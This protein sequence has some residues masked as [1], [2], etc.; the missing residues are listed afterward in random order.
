MP[1]FKKILL[2]CLLI[3]PLAVINAQ[4]VWHPGTPS[5]GTVGPLSVTLNYGL[6]RVGMVYVIVFNSNVVAD[7]TPAQIKTWALA[8]PVGGRVVSTTLTVG[9]GQINTN[10][11]Q[12]FTLFDASRTHAMYVVAESSPGG[13]QAVDTR[14]QFT[15]LSCPSIDILTGF[16]QPITCITQ[17]PLKTFQVVLFDPPTSGI[18]KGTTWTLDWGDGSPPSVYTSAADYDIP[19]LAFR[20]HLYTST[21][22][23][24]YIFTAVVRNPCG[25]TYSVQNNAIVHGRDIPADGNGLLSIVNNATGNP[26]VQVCE[27]VQTVVTLR[28]NSTWNC[29]GTIPEA[30]NNDTRNIE[31]LYGRNNGG[32]I[33]NTIT[34]TVAISGLGNAPQVSGRMIPTPYGSN[35]LSQ[36]ITIPAT[37]KAGE[38]IRVYLKN[39]NKCNPLDADF[40]STFVDIQVIPAPPAPTAPSR[41]VCIGEDRTLSVTSVPVGTTTWYS[42]AALLNPVGAGLNFVPP[43]IAPGTYNY[44]VTDRSASGLLCQSAPTLVSLIISPKPST[45]TITYPNKNNICYGVEPPESYTIT[46]SVSGTPP[47]SGFQWYR[48]GVALPGRTSDTIYITK[49]DETGRYTVRAVGAAPSFCQGDS[50]TGRTVTVHALLNVTPPADQAICVSGTAVFFAATTMAIDSWQWEVSYNGGVS[51]TTVG[52]SAPYDGFNTQTLTLTTPPVSF[53]GYWYRLEMK[54]PNGQGGCRFKSP[55]A[56]LTVDGLPTANAGTPIVRCAPNSFDPIP[57]IGAIRGGSAATVVWSGGEALGTWSQNMTPAL[58]TFTPSV[59]SGS[60]TATLTVTGTAACGGVVATS[61]RTISWSQTPVAVAGA[62]LIRCD[63]MPMA[64]FTMTGAN[65]TGTY[66]AQSWSGGAAL[67]TWTQNANPALAVFT[68][69]VPTGSFTAILSLAGSGTCTGSNITATRL[70]SWGQVPVVEAGDPLSRCDLTPLAPFNMTGASST[71]TFT[72]QAWT[73]GVGFGT[74]TQNANPSL[75]TF[76]PTVQSGSFTATLSLTGTGA[77]TGTNVADT[78]IIEW[79]HQATISAGPDQSICANGTVPLAGVMG[80]SATSVVWTG[81]MGTFNPNNTTLNAIYTPHADEKAANTVTLT[82]TTNDPSGICP[83]ATDDITISIGTVPTFAVLTSSGDWCTGDGVSWLRVDIT[84]GAPPYRIRYRRNGVNQADIFP[85][86]SGTNF[87]LGVLPVGNYTYEVYEIRDNCGNIFNTAPLPIS[88]TFTV[89]Q[90][91]VASAGSDEG[92]CGTLITSLSAIPSIGTGTWSVVSGPGTITFTPSVNSPNVTATAS[93]YGL[94]VVRWTE[95]NGGICSSSSDITIAYETIATAAAVS[96]NLCGTLSAALTGNTPQAGTGTWTLVSGPGTASF[97]PGANTPNATVTVSQYGSYRFRWTIANGI[98]CTSNAVVDVTFEKGAVAGPDQHLCNTFSALLA[99]N[100]PAV[101]TGIWSLVS[102]PGTVTFTPNNFTPAAT[103]TVTQYGSYVFN[104]KID[105]GAFCTTNSNVTVVYNPSGQVNDITSQVLC[106]GNSSTDII[107]STANAGGTTMYNWTNSTPAIGLPA[108]GSGDILSF[109]AQNAGTAPL[110]ATI[111]VT[112]VYFDGVVSCPGTPKSFTITVN[113]TAQVN[114]PADRF[115][116]NNGLSAAVILTTANTIGATSY[117]WSN[118]DPS[119]GLGAGGVGNIPAF[120]PVNTGLV[121]ITATVTVTPTFTYGTVSCPGPAETF[122]I[123]VN[124]SGQVDQP[125][126]VVI[127]NTSAGA[128]IFTTLIGGGITT[129]SWTNSNPAIGLPASGNGNIAFTGT[130][131]GTAPITGTIIVTPTFTNGGTGCPGPTKSFTITVN[132][133]GQVDQPINLTIC[134]GATGNVSFTSQNTIGTTTYH[135]SNSNTDIGLGT[136]GDGNISFS[137]T[138]PGTTPISATITVTPTFTFGSTG[139]SGPSKSFT[140]TINPT[141]TLAGTL[142]PPDI[143]SNTLFSYN[144]SSLTF[145]TTFTWNRAVVAGITPAGPTS[146]NDNPGEVLRNLTNI[147]IGVTYRYTLTSNG[148]ANVQNVIVNVKPE[149][150]IVPGQTGDICSGNATNY[151]ITL[152]NFINPVDNVVFTW[153]PPVLS[154]VNPLFTGGT[155][156]ASASSANIVDIYTNTMGVSGTATYSVT[157]YINGC[158][159]TP[160]DIVM[161]IRSQPVLA[162]GLNRTVCSSTPIGLILQTAAGSVLA[163]YYNISTVTLEAGLTADPGNAV[164]ANPIAPANYLANDRYLNLTGVDRTVTYRLQPI[165]D[166]DCFGAPVDVVITIR[167]QPFIIPAQARTV[168]SGIPIDKQVLLLPAN[169][170][171]G[172]IFNWPAPTLSDF[173]GQGTAGVNVTA[174]PSGK[175]HITDTITNLTGGPITA[176]YYI[177]PT[178]ASGCVGT[179]VSVVITINP[180]PSPALITGRDKICINEPNIVYTVPPVMGSTFTWTVAPGI[181]TKVFDFNSNAII[182]NAAAVPG[183]GAITLFETNFYGCAGDPSSMTVTVYP[184][185]VPE[186]VTGNTPVCAGSTNIYS[187]TNRPGSVYYWSIPSGSTLVGNPSASSVTII[188]GIVG[189]NIAVTETSIAGCVTVHTPLAVAVQPLPTA[190]MSGTA[191]ICDGGTGTLNVN[192]TGTAPFTFNYSVNGVPQI[193]ITTSDD[194]YSLVVTQAGNYTIQSVTDASGCTGPGFGSGFITYHFKPIGTL[195]GGGEICAGDSIQLTVVLTG[196]APFNIIYTDGAS[197]FTIPNHTNPILTFKVS[198]AVTSTFSLVSVTDV[199]G[200]EGLLSGTALVTINESPSLTL[201]GIDISCYDYTDGSVNLTITGTGPF[202]VAWTGPGGFIANSEDISGL[203]T[204]TYSVT[205]TNSKGCFATDFIALSQPLPLS[206]A[207]ASTNILCFGASDGTITLSAPSGGAGIYEYS[208]NGGTTWQASGNF[209]A[210][211][212]GTYDVRMRDAGTPLCVRTLNPALE[213]T[214]PQ[215]LNATISHTDLTCFGVATGTIT[216]SS[217]SGGSGSY[218]FSIDGGANWQGLGT[219]SGLTSGFYQVW[220]RDDIN[221]FCFRVLDAALEVTQ[222]AV[223]TATPTFTNVTCFG[224]GDGSITLNAPSGGSGVYQYSINGGT[225]W[226]SSPIFPNLLPGIYDVRM[227]DAINPSCA[228]LLQFPLNITQPGQLTATVTFTDATCNGG[229]DGTITI[230]APSGGYGTYDYSING[231]LSWQSSGNFTGLIAGTYNVRIRDGLNT[232]CFSI[233]NPTLVVG[234]P[235]SITANVAVTHV[236]C[237]AGTDGMI[238]ITAPAGGS[239]TYEYSR[240]AGLTWQASGIFP[241]LP[242]GY[243]NVQIRDAAQPLC[244]RVLNASLVVTQPAVLSAMVTPSMVT[245][246]GASTGSISITMPTGGTGNYEFTIDGGMSWQASGNFPSLTAGSY[247]VMMRDAVY[248]GCSTLLNAALV[249]SE[250]AILTGTVIK[251]D[252]TCFGA[253]DGRITITGQSG[254]TGS[255]QYSIDGIAWQPSALFTGLLPGTYSVMIRDAFHITCSLVLDAALIITEPALMTATVTSTD[256]TC[257]GTASG[258]ISITAP[259]G[260]YGVYSYSINGGLS[261]MASGTFTGLPAGT[262]DV[263]IRDAANTT[264][265]ITLDPAVVVGQQAQLSATVTSTDV[266][267]FGGSDGAITISAPM[268]GSGNYEYSIDAGV[269]WQPTGSYINLPPGFYNALMRDAVTPTCIRVLSGLL[270]INQPAMLS[271]MVTPVMVSCNGSADGEIV[272]AGASGGSGSYEYTSNG[273]TTWQASPIFSGLAAGV[274]N[275]KIR[276]AASIG[277]VI[278]LNGALTI[279]QPAVLNATVTPSNITCNGANNGT[280]NI[281][282]ASG[283][284]GT[285]DYSI[286]GGALWQPTGLFTALTPGSYDVVIRDRAHPMC[287]QI[288]SAGLVLTEPAVLTAT[289]APTGVTCFGANN[290]TITIS[291]PSGGYGTYSYSVNGGASWQGSGNFLNLLP[292]TYSVLM[293]DDANQACI[294]LLDGAVVIAEPALIAATISHTNVTCFGAA[295]GTITISGATGG[296]GSFEY[297]IN[298]GI[299]WQAS[300]SFTLL[301]PGYFNIQIRDLVNTGCVTVLSSSYG[302]TQPPMMA[303]FVFKTDITCNGSNNGTITISGSMGGSGSYEYSITGGAPWQ[304]SGNFAGLGAGT[305]N[306]QIRDGVNTG[307]VITLNGALTINE[308]AVL[309]GVLSTTMVSC[310]SGSDGRIIV[311]TPTGGSGFYHYSINGGSTWQGL[312]MF[313]NLPAGTYDVRMRDAASTACVVTLNAALVITEPALLT[314][315]IGS[316]NAS[317]FGAADG[318]ITMSAATGGSGSYEYSINGGGTWQASGNFTALGAGTYVILMRD[319]LYTGCVKILSAGYTLTQPTMLSATLSKTD[320]TC[321]GAANGTITISSPAGGYGTYEY[322]IDGGS[323]WLSSGTFNALTPGSYDVRMRDAAN[324]GCTLILFPNLAISEPLLLELIPTGDIILNCFG[325]MSGTG[326]FFSFG[327]TMPYTFTIVSN[328]TGA[329]TPAGGFSWQSFFNAGAGAITVMVEDANGCTA[330]ATI[331][332]TQPAQLTPGSIGSDQVICSGTVPAIIG[333][334]TA[335][336]GGPAAYNYQWQYSANIAGPYITIA[337]ATLPDYTPP[338]GT[339]GTLYYRR[340]VTSG[341]CIPVYSNIVQIVV[342]PIPVAMLTGGSTICPGESAPLVVNIMT[343]TGPFEVEIANHGIVTGYSSGNNIMVTPAFTT[344]YSLV[345]VRDANGCE[346][347]G[348][349]LNLTG[350]PTLTVRAL[351]V[352]TSSP[353]PVTVCEYSPVT[354]TAAATGTDIAWQWFVDEGAGF[355]PLTDGGNYAGSMTPALSIYGTPTIFDGNVYR[356][357]A[358]GCTVSVTTGTAVLTVNTAPQILQEPSDSTICT[359]ADASF[360]VIATGTGI[361]YRWQVNTGTGFSDVVNG[362]NFSGADQPTLQVINAPGSFNNYLFRVIVDGVCGAEAFSGYATLR[363]Y[364]APTVSLQPVNRSVC[365][366]GGPI[367]FLSYGS[368]LIDSIRW[369]VNTGSGWTDIYDNV[370]YTGAATQQ[371]ALWNVPAGFNGYRYRLALKARCTDVYSNEAVLT[372]NPKPVV[373][374]SAIDP[375]DVCGGTAVA[376]NGNPTGGSGIYTQHRWTGD[377]GPLSSFIVQSPTFQTTIGGTYNLTYTVTDSYGCSATD[378]LQVVVERPVAMFTPSITSGCSGL[379]ITFANNSVGHVSQSWDFGD[380]FTSTD[381]NPVHTYLNPTTSLMYFD[382]VLTVT[383]AGGCTDQ[384]QVSIAIYPLSISDFTVTD[385]TI[386]S[387]ETSIFVAQAGG[388]Q[389]HWVFGDGQELIG[390]NVATHTYINGTGIPVTHNVKVTVS[391]FFGCIS[392][393][394]RQITV[395][396][397]PIPQFTASPPTQSFPNAMVTFT[398]LTNAGTWSYLWRFGDGNTSTVTAPTHTYATPGDYTV[399]LIVTNGEC[400]DSISSLVR[401][402]P[403]PPISDFAEIPQGCEPWTATLVNNSQYGTSYLWDFGDGTYSNNVNPVHTWYLGGIYTV[404]LTVTGPGGV[405]ISSRIIEV[406]SAP[407]A[408]FKFSPEKVYVNDQYVRFYNLSKDATSYIWD[409]GDGDT[410]HVAEPAHKYMIKGVFDITLHAYSANG[411]VGSLTVSPGVTVESAGELRFPTAFRPNKDG[412]IEGPPT[413]A[414]IDMF[415]FPPVQEQVME[416][417]LQ[418]FNRWGALIFESRDINRGWNGYYKGKLVQQGVYVWLCEGKYSD[419]RPFRKVGDVTLLH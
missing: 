288:L 41:T 104:W 260:G 243:Y 2:F 217:P 152:A 414:T 53:S 408:L 312:G 244:S 22:S 255:Y 277:C 416:Y 54:T 392:E 348:P 221:T 62:S 318:T 410:S 319:A 25:E 78:R 286:D 147:P 368:G 240:D 343:G 13:L 122:T 44:Y 401:I 323:T 394:T 119:I 118:S 372:V 387:G 316:T 39:W 37:A 80:G 296:S 216:V 231:G 276:D 227:R 237:Y 328:T 236:T 59:S 378:N 188:F 87:S 293:R 406:Y 254:G 369:Q 264:C 102:G 124:P 238:S 262:Y 146:G 400:S 261:W 100:V 8:G 278:T 295:D 386:C 170:P 298:G 32:T 35:S 326:S 301:A 223:M 317:C 65:A 273:G 5:I 346:V 224:G 415:F 176:T 133:T 234:Q 402:L 96:E 12:I 74:W 340:M 263:R 81:G 179:T 419:G 290:G 165:H 150:V 66:S 364:I 93:A 158:A 112:P 198:P 34:G 4:P 200:C 16:S 69:S 83:P 274:Y 48:D 384:M 325:V 347:L 330:T 344:T 267:C 42:D 321:L 183:S 308:P 123:T 79:S 151:H 411:C 375:L 333:Q 418:I 345:R 356:A 256:A 361:T 38:Y 50:S 358:T 178:S 300:P 252:I 185:A 269:T 139:C 242:S 143:C 40:V 71:G 67:G 88:R 350:T 173:S 331:T 167:P 303:A 149:P 9:A 362:A 15:T 399:K 101:G 383:G 291:A 196:T 208:I 306:V 299:G 182:V 232:G 148:C 270:I 332:V 249:I 367:S 121:P 36:A 191:V 377:L 195:S 322:S 63:A 353:S 337:G 380:G 190:I 31:W 218:E 248:N 107:F 407:I 30:Q 97:S 72:G 141:P 206:A 374:F 98:F 251:V 154:P 365:A 75:A 57:M 310:N 130:N 371:L 226:Q 219:F 341:S 77:C 76:T 336:T 233:I 382:A 60:F 309:N 84:G 28:D 376:L 108:T 110:V 235:A 302:I 120:V 103:A 379:E 381:A 259:S 389:Y 73:G 266:T 391:S 49:P 117:S 94:Y 253:N 23:C 228:V 11:S 349:S 193:P 283:G 138:N 17:G 166:P 370:S 213:I 137:G 212:P 404:T 90:K 157:P 397:D 199:N 412:P 366:D 354:F 339:A 289:V 335:P 82:L 360:S 355:V 314:A 29:Q 282:F 245:C 1:S 184:T 127:C 172:T 61:T 359:A 187:V 171:A 241:N 211:A 125:V 155:G 250:P 351:P 304:P 186:P 281:T 163:D 398:N 258:T 220:I 329:T 284:Y 56:V 52:N 92:E 99:G 161:T 164:V 109:V 136:D 51:Y 105:N 95:V 313:L 46:A 307:C 160:E 68:P 27:G 135:W 247:S 246:N 86:T 257:F 363:V 14:L 268:G 142:T 24:Y 393:T 214:S 194:P 162:T 153:G 113:P 265:I 334:L 205:V 45:P 385:D 58:A 395:Y 129:Y 47:V 144:P 175:F 204:G 168:C 373:D 20:Q 43:Q 126:N 239:G 10:L 26:V 156:R 91:P 279:T 3:I 192:F 272:I 189:G 294:M 85:Y 405:D 413:P 202:G 315:T 285:Y 111:Q 327:G 352:I 145:G 132:P 169:I 229:N 275:V 115:V 128:A 409:F 311:G 338:A 116:C 324:I 19:P 222:P 70:I 134:N 114:K 174:D 140:I 21:T 55:P 225:V 230:S 106:N 64:P 320:V 292:G 18:L 203:K 403:T 180:E 159:G 390:N 280:I 201:S 33:F 215:Q 417:K 209:T 305:Y 89:W 388:F 287:M 210:L 131:A 297:S 7:L 342:N 6:D 207:L 396:P 181:G 271:A 177:T 197:N 357:V